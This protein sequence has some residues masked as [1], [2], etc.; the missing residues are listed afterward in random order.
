MN[1]DMHTAEKNIAAL[2]MALTEG[3]VNLSDIQAELQACIDREMQKSADQID[4]DLVKACQEMLYNSY[5]R[6]NPN[7]EKIIPAMSLEELLPEE[8]M[9]QPIWKRWALRVAV[10]TPLV[11]LCF[12]GYDLLFGQRGV[13]VRQSEDE[14]QMYVSGYSPEA[15]LVGSGSAGN[16]STTVTTNSIEEAELLLGY[17]VPMTETLL[18]DWQLVSITASLRSSRNVVTASYTQPGNKQS[19]VYTLTKV[20]NY[21]NF[22][23]LFEQNSEGMQSTTPGGT[24][25]YIAQNESS[26]LLFW[27][28]G[29]TLFSIS[30]PVTYDELYLIV[31]G[32]S[33]TE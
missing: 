20:S 29:L 30:G 5:D 14:Q 25:V 32:L 17:S 1:T 13:R 9:V 16:Q 24:D 4:G 11:L 3:K 12:L 28:E 10:V 19:I 21:D 18:S 31:D 6:R 15:V 2:R 27:S 33:K 23:T 7:R 22:D 8:K 26:T